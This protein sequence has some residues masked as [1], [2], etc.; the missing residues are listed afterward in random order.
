MSADLH[1]ITSVPHHW[2]CESEQGQDNGD[3]KEGLMGWREKENDTSVE[4][5][6][7]REKEQEIEKYRKWELDAARVLLSDCR[8]FHLARHDFTT[9]P[10]FADM[11]SLT[12]RSLRHPALA[13]SRRTLSCKLLP[14]SAGTCSSHTSCFPAFDKSCSVYYYTDYWGKTQIPKTHL[15]WSWAA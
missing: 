12:L 13:W 3:V 15:G 1:Y 9:A 7:M 10:L 2:C 5:T 8:L 6:S 14:G 11:T 4:E